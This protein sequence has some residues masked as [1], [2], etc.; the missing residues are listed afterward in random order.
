[1]E[2]ELLRVGQF[3]LTT[4]AAIDMH[5]RRGF[6]TAIRRGLL[7]ASGRT[8]SPRRIPIARDAARA[9]SC[10]PPSAAGPAST[11]QRL[12][13][14]FRRFNRLLSS[15]FRFRDALH[16][17]CDVIVEPVLRH[18]GELEGYETELSVHCEQAAA[19]PILPRHI[20][21]G[22]TLRPLARAGLLEAGRGVSWPDPAYC[23][24]VPA[25]DARYRTFRTIGA[26]ASSMIRVPPPT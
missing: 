20:G 14:R 19:R 16:C 25:T 1:M 24:L 17:T 3:G 6:S 13:P 15:L 9:S 23:T 18:V 21:V 4:F 2:Q 11:A 8:G 22:R 26:G 10:I 5:A 12:R 7:L